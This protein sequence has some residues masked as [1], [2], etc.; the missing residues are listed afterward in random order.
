MLDEIKKFKGAYES[1]DDRDYIA[2]H[3]LGDPDIELPTSVNLDNVP[4][5][6]QGKTMHC[7]AY[8]VSHIV[9]I[10]NTKEFNKPALVDPEEQWANQKYDKGG[11]ESMEDRGDSLR[12]ALDV[13]IQKGLNNKSSEIP[14]P[15]Y[16]ADTYASVLKTAQDMKKWLARGFPVYT[17]SINHAFCVV[18]YD[19]TKKVFI[20]KNSFG[21]E[22]GK[23]KNGT[24]EINYDDVTSKLFTPYVIF[25][26]KDIPMIFQ[27]VSES[28]PMA[29]DIKF[30]LD[31]GLVKGYGSDPDPKKRLFKPDQPVTRAE[32]ASMM[33][34]V[35]KALYSLKYS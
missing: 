20:A 16:N 34:K 10:M 6:S 7:T 24:F 19:D 35:Y 27:D 17:G 15:T 23:K 9:E 31:K 30:C 26:K 32:M 2:S 14:I 22:W 18:G 3:I 11:N 13:Y 1:P 12:H 8:G 28:S 29:D 21:A 33:S 25:D 5:H 4:S